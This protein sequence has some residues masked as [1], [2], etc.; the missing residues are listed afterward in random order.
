L[1]V[2]ITLLLPFTVIAD[3]VQGKKVTI[4]YIQN[5]DI[6]IDAQFD[7]EYSKMNA[8]L[9]TEQNLDRFPTSPQNSSGKFWLCH[10]GKNIYL[11]VEVTDSNIDYS[12]NIPAA[13]WN[14]ESIGIIL[15][16][17]YN[18][19]PNNAYS[20][21]DNVC[22]INLSGD[23]V[24]VT[25]HK[26]DK[27]H[28]NGLYGKIEY[29]TIQQ[30]S[31]SQIIYEVKMPIPETVNI[32]DTTKVGFEVCAV[33]AENAA[34]VGTV[35]WSPNG[36]YMD[37]RTDVLGT[38]MFEI[39]PNNNS[40][41]SVS[42]TTSSEV[43]SNSSTSSES[44]E[45]SSSVVSNDSSNSSVSSNDSSD[46]LSTDSSTT[47]D[48]S[49]ESEYS[50]TTTDYDDVESTDPKGDSPTTGFGILYVLG[51]VMTVSLVACLAVLIFNKKKD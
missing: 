36:A 18:R 7:D 13:T 20:T 41:S 10:D 9:L 12:H 14:R 39:D 34:R 45:N 50:D 5:G 49:E 11:Y 22:Y 47:S 15:D 32:N 27:E 6:V 8:E 21:T 3:D 33:N 46:I 43:S 51:A 4:P 35:T 24:L 23:G 31:L 48:S 28:Y 16:F 26:Y 44:S 1:V 19:T 42:S 25:Y 29:E 40:S 37:V 38:I 30:N 17:D 2:G